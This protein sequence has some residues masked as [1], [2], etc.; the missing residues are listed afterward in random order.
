M[1]NQD[2]PVTKALVA[3]S[4]DESVAGASTQ[5]S[6]RAPGCRCMKVIRL[7]GE[8]IVKRRRFPNRNEC[9]PGWSEI[10]D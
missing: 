7:N 8:E 1:S 4:T 3:S 10:G 6:P 5:S 2:T 9:P